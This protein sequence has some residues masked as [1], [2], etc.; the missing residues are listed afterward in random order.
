[1]PDFWEFDNISSTTS[2]EDQKIDMQLDWSFIYIPIIFFRFYF[3]MTMAS[4]IDRNNDAVFTAWE[5]VMPDFVTNQSHSLHCSSESTTPK[6]KDA[7]PKIL[8]LFC[9][10]LTSFYHIFYEHI[11]V[12][13]YRAP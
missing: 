10:D 7:V 8:S 3:A 1:M 5:Q 12:P 4:G 6:A 11:Q 13:A 2:A 9:H